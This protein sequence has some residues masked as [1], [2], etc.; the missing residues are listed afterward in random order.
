MPGRN[1]IRIL[2]SKAAEL[3]EQ[4]NLE[5]VIIGGI[6][7]NVW[8]NP[9]TTSDIDIVVLL[10]PDRYAV[11]LKLAAKHGFIFNFKKALSQLKKMGMCRLMK[12]KY[13][14]DFIMGYSDFEKTVFER[15]RKIEIFGIRI[16]VASPEDVIL[17]KL[18]SSRNI[19]LADMSNIVQTQA[20]KLDVKYLRARALQMQTD[21]S[22][23]DILKNLE[24]LLAL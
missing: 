13:H 9:R 7:V 5:Y 11:F 6:A 24:K 23:T 12:D 14:V 1:E 19:D 10:S 22:R 2:L 20:G 3:T 8:G 17:Y 21:L 16:W 15:K 4:E 18:L